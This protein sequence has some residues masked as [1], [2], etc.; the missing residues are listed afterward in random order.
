VSVGDEIACGQVVCLLEVM[1]TFNRIEYGGHGLPGRARVLA[2]LPSD[3]DDLEA[4]QPVLSLA[5]VG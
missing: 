4:G 2:V 3:G 5:R 1:K